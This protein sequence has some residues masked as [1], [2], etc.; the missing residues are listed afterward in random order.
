MADWDKLEFAFN[1]LFVGPRCPLAPPFASCYMDVER[2]LMGPTT[3]RVRGMRRACGLAAPLD[4]PSL[5][6]TWAWSWT[7][8]CV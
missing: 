5:T 3:L 7:P 6:T 4:T 1:R 8:A 2:T